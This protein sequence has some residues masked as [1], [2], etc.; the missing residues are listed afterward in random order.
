[1]SI[2]P[3]VFKGVK[4][5]L[6]VQEVH[7]YNNLVNSGKAEPIRVPGVSDDAIVVTRVDDNDEVYFYDL[8]ENVSVYPGRNTIEKIKNALAMLDK[9]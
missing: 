8:M 6:T 1:M 7:S 2:L 5:K 3:G 4:M 9:A